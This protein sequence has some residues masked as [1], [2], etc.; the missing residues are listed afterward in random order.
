MSGGNNLENRLDD[1]LESNLDF[2]LLK[3]YIVEE[4]ADV[5]I[6]KLEKGRIPSKFEKFL[7][8]KVSEGFTLPKKIIDMFYPTNEEEGIYH[9]V[10]SLVKRGKILTNSANLKNEIVYSVFGIE[11]DTHD[12]TKKLYSVNKVRIKNHIFNSEDIF[13]YIFTEKN[14]NGR[15]V[16]KKDISEQFFKYTGKERS[17]DQLITVGGKRLVEN[18]FGKGMYGIFNYAHTAHINAGEKRALAN[19]Y[20]V[21]PLRVAYRIKNTCIEDREDEEYSRA[22]IIVALLH[23]VVESG[24]KLRKKKLEEVAAKITESE[25]NDRGERYIDIM[26]AINKNIENPPELEKDGII[27]LFKKNKV[28]GEKIR[29]MVGA[30]SNNSKQEYKSYIQDMFNN[31]TMFIYDDELGM[32]NFYDIVL[33]VKLADAIDNTTSLH[34][35][36][37]NKQIERIEH[38]VILATETI[39]FLNSN[40]IDII[41]NYRAWD[42]VEKLISSSSYAVEEIAKSIG[43]ASRGIDLKSMNRNEGKYIQMKE[44]VYSLEEGVRKFNILKEK[45]E[46]LRDIYLRKTD[47]WI[48]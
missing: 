36:Y 21:H 45:V 3:K 13:N 22:A 44:D 47:I 17:L 28:F 2:S 20:M 8:D 24:Q 18:L 30:I 33:K 10:Y 31:L 46:G 23:D 25:F 15:T 11:K 48:K 4:P 27:R 37:A 40:S 9:T 12:E 1:R 29:L 38:N 42:M 14:D 6:R 35:V 34:G 26:R 16:L 32:K 39:R 5:L 7:L 43:S 41:K 19:D